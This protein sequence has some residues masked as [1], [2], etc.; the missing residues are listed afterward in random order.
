MKSI[1]S[2]VL[3]RLN[4]TS[5]S[6]SLN[7][8][9]KLNSNSKINSRN[10]KTDKLIEDIAWHFNVEGNEYY[11]WIEKWINKYNITDVVY[12]MSKDDYR[13]AKS[14]LNDD[15]NNVYGFGFIIFRDDKI[16][17]RYLKNECSES[18]KVNI[19]K[20]GYDED[21]ESDKVIIHHAYQ[22]IT[23]YCL[24]KKIWDKL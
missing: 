3:E 2:F 8:R 9:L 21:W 12:L 14:E 7:E 20:E 22:S 17:N 13:I 16:I 1:K 6:I 24:D 18:N 23:T 5:E 19:D 4:F 10:T 11:Q 15:P